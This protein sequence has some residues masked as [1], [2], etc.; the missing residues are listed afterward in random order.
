MNTKEFYERG[1]ELSQGRA[2]ARRNLASCAQRSA[3]MVSVH[4]VPAG[5]GVTAR[6]FANQPPVC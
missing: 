2:A 6:H 3:V 4:A 1:A 5:L